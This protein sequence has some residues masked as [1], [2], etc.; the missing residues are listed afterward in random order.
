MVG[1]EAGTVLC[2]TCKKREK[3]AR[4]KQNQEHTEPKELRMS[5]GTA[6]APSPWT[7]KASNSEGGDFELPAGGMYPAVLVSLIDLGTHER[8]FNNQTTENR[9]L[10]FVWELTAECDSKGQPFIVAQD[11]TWSLHKKAKLRAMVEAWRGKAMNDDEEL[12]LISLLGKPCMLTLA[13][14][15]TSSKKKYVEVSAVSN[16]PKGLTV[17]PASKTLFAF[18]LSFIGS[19]KDDLGIP[20][21]IPPIYGR[22]ITDEI[23][24]SKEYGNLPPY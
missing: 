4:E 5:T 1:R 9:K 17:P 2:R 10:F 22:D 12:D 13:E 7:A 19:T 6:A 18:N 14:G 23:K 15:E 3:K 8:T 20:D 16:P 21:W 11:Y 24:K